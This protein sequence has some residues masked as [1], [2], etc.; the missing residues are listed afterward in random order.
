VRRPAKPKYAVRG[1]LQASAGR[2]WDLCSV[3]TWGIRPVVI[4]RSSEA[5]LLWVGRQVFSTFVTKQPLYSP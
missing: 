3:L 2:V 5:G 4:T 1:G